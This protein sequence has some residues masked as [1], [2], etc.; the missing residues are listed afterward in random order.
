MKESANQMSLRK[1]ASTLAFL[2]IAFIAFGC[3]ANL[4][5]EFGDKTSEAAILFEAKQLTNEGD[6]SGAI[7]KLETLSA[8]S[9]A[10]REI[11]QFRASLYAGRCGLDMLQYVKSLSEISVTNSLFMILVA[12]QVADPDHTDCATAEDFL[13]SIDND[14]A[15]R[16]EGENLLMAFTSLA[17]IGAVLADQADA[18]NDGV[19]DTGYSA[20]AMSD[21]LANQMVVGL[22]LAAKSLAETTVGSGI[23]GALGTIC[24]TTFCDNYE[25]SD[26]DATERALMKTATHQNGDVGLHTSNGTV[27]PP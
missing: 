15:D 8:T 21:A 1:L 18:D 27:C 9:L 20:C 16:T 2:A 6:W 24:T 11:V 10:K 12:K 5:S 13:Q 19:A 4:L 23:N 26:V 14:A 3:G 7:T 22:S 25:T 17:K